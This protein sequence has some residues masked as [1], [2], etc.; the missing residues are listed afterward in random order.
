MRS[1]PQAANPSS[2]PPLRFGEGE[3]ALVPKLC[4]G[5]RRLEALLRERARTGAS[6]SARASMR[7]SRAS[8]P[9]V[10]KQSL[11][12]RGC[13]S[14]SPPRGGGARRGSPFAALMLALL[15]V[16][17]ARTADDSEPLTFAPSAVDLLG[18]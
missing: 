18:G 10:P 14:P 9:G 3:K 13:C 16:G 6:S 12:T 4:L 17:P 7:R 1:L 11:G 5:T 15:V 8:G 2:L